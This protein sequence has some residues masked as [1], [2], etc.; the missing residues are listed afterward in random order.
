MKYDCKLFAGVFPGD[1]IVFSDKGN[2]L[3]QHTF[4]IF[5]VDVFH[6]MTKFDFGYESDGK[7]ILILLPIP[8][9][10][11]VSVNESRPRPADVGERVG[12]YTIYN[13][14]GFLGALDRNCL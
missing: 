7:K 3:K 5:K 2:G 1:P 11:F 14:T 6:I 9:N 12:D 4:W 13:S 10:F 8:R